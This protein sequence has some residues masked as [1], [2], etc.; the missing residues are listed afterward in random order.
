MIDIPEGEQRKVFQTHFVHGAIFR[1][2][3]FIFEDKTAKPKFILI[4]N[5]KDENQYC[6]FCL[7]TSNVLRIRTNPLK[8]DR[9]YILPA[10]T[11]NCFP[12]ETAIEV[13]SIRS[14]EYVWFEEK[15]ISHAFGYKLEYK[16]KMPELIMNDIKELILMSPYLSPRLKLK[17]YPAPG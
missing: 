13:T 3:K 1:I 7:P 17:I 9:S 10:G 14:K 12:K 4:L 8:F 16:Q 15:Y 6:H 11:V 5:P 2:E